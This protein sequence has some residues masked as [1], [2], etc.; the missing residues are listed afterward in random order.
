M[1]N[2]DNTISQKTID[3]SPE[4]MVIP[5][6]VKP[7]ET[8]DY[9]LIKP[10]N[11]CLIQYL[12]GE[13]ELTKSNVPA[14]ETIRMLIRQYRTFYE[15][16]DISSRDKKRIVAEVLDKVNILSSYREKIDDIINSYVKIAPLDPLV[17]WIMRVAI[18]DLFI[19]KNIDNFNQYV[20]FTGEASLSYFPLVHS[21]LTKLFT[22]LDPLE[23]KTIIGLKAQ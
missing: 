23:K 19:I 14:E 22:S 15:K 20:C 9:A 4:S 8:A 11:W 6:I 1:E 21:F 10:E 5:P 13:W 3:D 12:F 2:I 17:P 7:Q 18:L 16:N